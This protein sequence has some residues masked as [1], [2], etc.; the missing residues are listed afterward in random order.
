MILT[1]PWP[2]TTNNAY[3][4]VNGRRVKTRTARQY[5]LEAEHATRLAYPRPPFTRTDRLAITI[6]LYPPDRRAFDIANREKL[7]IDAIAP[8][9]GFNDNQIDQLLIR[10]NPPTQ[11]PHASI[12]IHAVR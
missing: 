6:D 1:L 5:A 4:T 3:A 11:L 2:P 12:S 9:L 7:L 10:R 8:A